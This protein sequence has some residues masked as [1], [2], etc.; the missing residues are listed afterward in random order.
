MRR[1]ME[2]A[3][4]FVSKELIFEETNDKKG[5]RIEVTA[6]ELDKASVGN[7][8]VYKIE[9]GDVI[10]ESLTKQPVYYGTTPWLKHDNPIATPKS[11]KEPVGFVERA[12][13]FG[14]KIKAIV[15]ITAQSLIE[16][17][18]QGTKYLFSVGGVALAETVK[19]LG[20]KILHILHG[21]RCNHLQIVD[22]STSVGFPNAK[23]DKLIEINET[24]M[25]VDRKPNIAEEH[26]IEVVGSGIA[27]FEVKTT[28]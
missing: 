2:T 6:M 14:K 17:L 3:F 23:M 15:R 10:A 27:G 7:N 25:F 19:N 22:L 11:K 9:E 12:W 20:G 18:K 16:S 5:A 1:V 4:F 28:G 26:I 24:V 21:A 13:R 8:R